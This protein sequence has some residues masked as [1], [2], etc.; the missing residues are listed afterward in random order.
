VIGVIALVSIVA[1]VSL[2]LTRKR[3]NKA[4]Q[5]IGEMEDTSQKP[6]VELAAE[7]KLKELPGNGSAAEL[8]G[9]THMGSTKR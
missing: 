7:E 9:S 6:P 1:A 3:K 4:G 2:L 8:H 5:A